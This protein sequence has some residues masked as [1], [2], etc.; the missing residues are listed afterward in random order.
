MKTCVSFNKGDGG[1]GLGKL[2]RGKSEPLLGAFEDGI[3]DGRVRRMHTD[4][5]PAACLDKQAL[6]SVGA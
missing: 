2:S 4:P 3:L 5:A 6:L 1:V